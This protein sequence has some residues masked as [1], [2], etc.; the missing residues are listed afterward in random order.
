MTTGWERI[1][2]SM[3]GVTNPCHPVDAQKE[4]FM[5]IETEIELLEEIPG[6]QI[7]CNIGQGRE[8]ILAYYASS[9]T[10]EDAE[11]LTD[12]F[13]A[14][15]NEI[16]NE[17]KRWIAPHELP[18]DYY[19]FLKNYGGLLI[20]TEHIMLMLLGIGPRT[21]DLYGFLMGD[22]A[23]SIPKEDGFLTIGLLQTHRDDLSQLTWFTYLLDLA[24]HVH[25]GAVLETF[26]SNEENL[27]IRKIVNNRV[28]HQKC[29]KVVAKSFTEFLHLVAET[30][31]SLGKL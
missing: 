14:R 21:E 7:D 11:D 26:D 3:F 12:N 10:V 2:S 8:R 25:K 19:S 6:I 4:I 5:S 1:V 13:T 22:E 31:G 24:G 29:W 17:L 30:E 20:E 28:Q 27:G 18:G 16:F 15:I 23:Y 9:Y